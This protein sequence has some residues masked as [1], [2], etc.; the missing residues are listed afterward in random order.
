MRRLLLAIPILTLMA[1]VLPAYAQT[2]PPKISITPEAPPKLQDVVSRLLG[3]TMWVAWMAAIGLGIYA[4]IKFMTGD[5]E[6]VAAL[7]NWLLGVIIVASAVSIAY[8]LAGG[9]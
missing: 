6:A 1:A 4:G 2:T 9:G 7:R 3:L 8:W 5:K